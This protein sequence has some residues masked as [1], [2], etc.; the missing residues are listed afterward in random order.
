MRVFL[1]KAGTL[2]QIELLY[3][4]G[5]SP[6]VTQECETDDLFKFVSPAASLT[7]FNTDTRLNPD[8]ALEIRRGDRLVITCEYVRIFDG[9]VGREV[10]YDPAT[11]FLSFTGVGWLGE[12]NRLYAG[13]SSGPG[14]AFGG[15]YR[16]FKTDRDANGE[17]I[18][19]YLLPIIYEQTLPTTDRRRAGCVKKWI[20]DTR[21]AS[22]GE[23]LKMEEDSPNTYQRLAGEY[24]RLERSGNFIDITFRQLFDNLIEQINS[25]TLTAGRYSLTNTSFQPGSISSAVDFVTF[26]SNEEFRFLAGVIQS[27]EVYLIGI[28]KPSDQINYNSRIRIMHIISTVDIDEFE[29]LELTKWIPDYYSLDPTDTLSALPASLLTADRVF[30]RQY[31]TTI[32]ITHL[33]SWALPSDSG[34]T[35]YVTGKVETFVYNLFTQEYTRYY[36]ETVYYPALTNPRYQ[37]PSLYLN[38]YLNANLTSHQF[39]TGSLADESYNPNTALDANGGIYTLVNGLAVYAGSPIITDCRLDAE[40]RRIVDLMVDVAKLT[41]SIL[42]IDLNKQVWLVSRD[43]YN[44]GT[45]TTLTNVISVRHIIQSRERE[46]LPQV[47]TDLI[48]NEQFQQILTDYYL[49]TRFPL[50]EDK[51]E[52]K[53]LT[54]AVNAALELFDRVL[55][56]G[57]ADALTIRRIEFTDDTTTITATKARD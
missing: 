45:P 14:G 12:I 34:E 16:Y 10:N 57:E 42:H 13:R 7:V 51:Y 29:E 1:I 18:E 35:W 53:V 26:L 44:A 23:V 31:E 41:D 40:N 3:P 32:Q 43:Y 48:E 52:I 28:G 55:I 47:S 27:G 8:G 21:V 22:R 20:M 56:D 36:N 38:A 46:E 5:M 19:H 39:N 37:P 30:V 11:G 33:Q 25:E 4:A 50:V 9:L 54:T 6:T 15:R 2:A 49:D 17:T 24:T